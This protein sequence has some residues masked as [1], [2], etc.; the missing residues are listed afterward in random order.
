[1]RSANPALVSLWDTRKR[2]DWQTVTPPLAF[3][4]TSGTDTHP[5][6]LYER[7]GW[8]GLLMFTPCVVFTICVDGAMFVLPRSSPFVADFTS[9]TLRLGALLCLPL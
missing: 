1:M 2:D 3:S 5:R 9:S 6:T 8:D 7:A 4:V